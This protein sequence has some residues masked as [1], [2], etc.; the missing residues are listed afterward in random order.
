MCSSD[1]M[2]MNETA[3]QQRVKR[4]ARDGDVRAGIKNAK[5]LRETIGRGR[6]EKEKKNIRQAHLLHRI[7][8]PVVMKVRR[9]WRAKIDKAYREDRRL[10][11]RPDQTRIRQGS[12]KEMG[13]VVGNFIRQQAHDAR[14]NTTH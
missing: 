2:N 13:T 12:D 6:R 4:Q 10:N 11:G 1:L 3:R 9:R 5:M 14:K 8:C 7:N